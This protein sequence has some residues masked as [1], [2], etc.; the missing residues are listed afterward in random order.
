MRSLLNFTHL[1]FYH[2]TMARQLRLEY[3][4]ALYHITSRGNAQAAIYLVDD[5]RVAFKGLESGI[6]NILNY[7]EV[8]PMTRSQRLKRMPEDIGR[9]GVILRALMQL[10]DRGHLLALLAHLQ[11]IADQHQTVIEP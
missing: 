4:G 9:F 6:W 3:E 11:P 7:Q 10:F 2:R 5:D 1:P 8:S